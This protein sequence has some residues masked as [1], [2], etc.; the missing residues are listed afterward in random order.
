MGCLGLLTS[1]RSPVATTLAVGAALAVLLM[2]AGCDRRGSGLPAAER[3]TLA[4]E[5][6]RGDLQQALSAAGAAAGDPLFIRIFKEEGELEVWLQPGQRF[7]LVASFEICNW[8]GELGPK[9]RE[10]DGQAPEG[11]YF[12]NRGRMNPNSRYHLAF[13]LGYPN[14]YDRAHGRTGSALMVH[15]DC[16]SIGCYAMTDAGIEKIYGLADAALAN[17]QELFRVHVFPFRMTDEKLRR[18]RDS[19]WHDFWSNLK[20]GHDLFEATRIPPN[21]RVEEGRYVFD[22]MSDSATSPW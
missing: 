7:V 1:R 4:A 19:E 17:G 6:V 12:V 18:H 5:R 2:G 9:L 15:G 8:S 11:F 3:E 10:G 20:E 21:V 16:V 22:A 13:N 14:A